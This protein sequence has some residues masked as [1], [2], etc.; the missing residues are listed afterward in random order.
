MFEKHT[1]SISHF[2]QLP[3]CL[4][5]H[6]SRLVEV[7]CESESEECRLPTYSL[8][9]CYWISNIQSISSLLLTKSIPSLSSVY[10][11][12]GFIRT[13]SSPTT[14]PNKTPGSRNQIPTQTL[15]PQLTNRPQSKNSVLIFSMC[16]NM[17]PRHH[18]QVLPEKGSS[19][20]HHKFTSSQLSLRKILVLPMQQNIDPKPY[21][22]V[23]HHT[24]P[25][26]QR[27]DQ[28]LERQGGAVLGFV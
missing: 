22:Q 13:P 5:S 25:S 21:L 23:L 20:Q 24:I 14:V 9:L 11:R 6:L 16:R 26:R 27:P 7:D 28:Y 3:L 18:L 1:F 19:L 4:V 2:I 8:T 15:T 12:H 10:K 17:V